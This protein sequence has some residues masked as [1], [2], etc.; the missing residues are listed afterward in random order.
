MT[1]REVDLPP[2]KS[3]L[4]FFESMQ[5]QQALPEPG[6]GLATSHT[7]LGIM[8]NLGDVSTH[9]LFSPVKSPM[10]RKQN[11]WEKKRLVLFTCS[12]TSIA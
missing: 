9:V 7:N 1:L 2:E 5:K 12:V 11:G 6:M 8:D 10:V 3:H 4:I